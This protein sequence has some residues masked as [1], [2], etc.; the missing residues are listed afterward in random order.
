[1]IGVSSGFTV[2]FMIVS[3][4]HKGLEQLYS[5]GVAKGVQAKHVPK[6]VRILFS[7]DMAKSISELNHENF[8][9]HP[10]RGNLEGF[11]SVSVSGNWRIVFRFIGE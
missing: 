2:V 8:R 6:I 3:F 4:K 11:Y 5:T 10:L 1:M 7:L 9:L